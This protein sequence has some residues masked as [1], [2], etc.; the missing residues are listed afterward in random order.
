VTSRNT[1]EDRAR[2]EQVGASGYIVKSE[3]DQADLIGRIRRLVA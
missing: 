3:F 1:P 2:G